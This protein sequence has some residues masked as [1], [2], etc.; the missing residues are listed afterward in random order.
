MKC[1]N[2]GNEVPNTAKVCGHCG[3]RLKAAAPGHQ[4]KT[5]IEP[6]SAP[7][8]VPAWRWGTIAGV[9]AIFCLVLLAGAGYWLLKFRVPAANEPPAPSFAPTL[10][11]TTALPPTSVPSTQQTNCNVAQFISDLD[12]PDGATMTPGQ[13][14]TKSWRIKNI[15]TCT[16]TTDYL[17]IFLSGDQMTGAGSQALPGN[18][19][20][21]QEVDLSVSLIAPDAGGNYIGGYALQDANEGIFFSLTVNI[22]VQAAATKQIVY[23]VRDLDDG[24]TAIYTV[25]I[26][27]SGTHTM[28]TNDGR[29]PDGSPDGKKIVFVSERDGDSQIYV[30]DADGGSQTRL[31]E[32]SSYDICPAWSPDGQQIAFVSGRHG[33]YEIYVINADGS[34]ERRITHNPGNDDC[35]LWSPDGQQLLFVSDRDGNYEI[36]I[37]SVNGIG[38]MRLTNDSRNDE[39]PS[40]SPDGQ[41]IAFVSDRDGNNEIYT[42]NVNGTGVTRLTNNTGSKFYPR[43]TPDGQN[44]IFSGNGVEIMNADGSNQTYY[45]VDGR[46]EWSLDGEYIA[47][48]ESRSDN[49]NLYDLYV[50]NSD[51]SNQLLLV[52][53]VSYE[54]DWLP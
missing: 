26:D 10:P 29:M 52:E 47:F 22:N 11:L 46:P 6:V 14:F 24:D 48:L 25:D 45:S 37:A 44:I 43:W 28:L 1:T 19:M 51:G 15:G 23:V 32:N 21:G 30:M 53:G 18:V 2:C 17:V 34:G 41:Q 8:A 39:S 20:P 40:W 3:H 35:P 42:M 49:Y 5:T 33:N 36:Y 50:A 12:V 16:W 7:G 31:T 13:T 38:E 27:G 54:F 4:P 9:G